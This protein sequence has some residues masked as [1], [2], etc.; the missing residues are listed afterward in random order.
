MFK[1]GLNQAVVLRSINPFLWRDRRR[2]EELSC[3][4]ISRND[5]FESSDEA[6]ISEYPRPLD[7]PITSSLVPYL[8][9]ILENASKTEKVG[10][11]RAIP[12]QRF[13]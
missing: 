11:D 7:Q 9:Q 5:E 13:A 12:I 1:F 2:L 6:P 8:I 3:V 10:S 4:R